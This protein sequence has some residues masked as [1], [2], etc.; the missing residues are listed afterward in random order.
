[1]LGY[2]PWRCMKHNLIADVVMK[3]RWFLKIVWENF[4]VNNLRFF[5]ARIVK[6]SKTNIFT[7]K[8]CAWVIFII[9]FTR[10]LCD[11]SNSLTYE[12]RKGGK[13]QHFHVPVVWLYI[14]CTL[15]FHNSNSDL[16]VWKP[17]L[18]CNQCLKKGSC[19]LR[20]NSF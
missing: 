18:F 9:L 2:Q 14:S 6:G 7:C 15:A 4:V 17:V 20:G 16:N 12:S 1:M 5:K 10:L 3:P 13:V 11:N 8:L 19:L